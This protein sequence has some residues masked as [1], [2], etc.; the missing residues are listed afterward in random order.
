MAATN[1]GGI[2]RLAS[3]KARR[4]IP[5]ANPAHQFPG[6][7]RIRLIRSCAEVEKNTIDSRCHQA[8]KQGLSQF[9]TFFGAFLSMDKDMLLASSQ[10]RK[11]APVSPCQ[12]PTSVALNRPTTLLIK[13]DE[14][15]E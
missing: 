5:T 10:E 6:N 11:D 9:D 13:F 1:H 8:K 3:G 2:F 12:T 4:R 15:S 7:A 14:G